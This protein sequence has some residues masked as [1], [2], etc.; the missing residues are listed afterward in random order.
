MARLGSWEIDLVKETSYWSE[1]TQNI[2]E[3]DASYSAD[4]ETGISF[5]PEGKHRDLIT[6]KV[7]ECILYGTPWDVELLM[8]TA[9]GNLKWVRAIGE[10]E[11]VNGT[12]RRLYGSIQDINDRKV[13]ELTLLK[14]L[15][16][17]NTILESIDDAFFAVDRQ[18]IV[19]YWN[20]QVEKQ[21]GPHK[22][23]ML[24]QNLWEVFAD[25]VNSYS[26]HKYAE[27]IE[28][29][30]VVRFEDYYEPMVRWYEISAF[31]SDSGLS[32]YFKDIT[33]RKLTE[34]R[35]N[36]LNANLQK[37][38]KELAMS[39]AELEQFA[40][41]ASHDL[42]EPLRMITGFLTQLER[43]YKDV[44]DEKGK[45]YIDFA[46]DG[47]KRMRHIILDLLEF[48]RVGRTDDKLEK[49][50]LSELV[51]EI[52]ILLMNQIEE[53]SAVI[54]KTNLPVIGSYKTQLR[55]VLLNLIGNA[56]K[57]IKAGI[58]PV[59]EITAKEFPDHWKMAVA[60]NGIGIDAEYF[61]K[62]FIIFQ[63]LHHKDEFP[64]TGMGLAI[65]KKIVESLGGK[66]WVESVEGKGS[67]FYFTVEKTK[68]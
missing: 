25:S 61:E 1:I 64:G 50:D 22:D 40:Y 62:I 63:R 45:R 33:H 34:I 6:Q 51:S 57:Y 46:V 29:N 11:F 19:T 43:K 55:Q 26:Y 41:V 42:Q 4:I 65:T 17:K 52:E 60:D 10:G 39:N 48:S 5:Y 67:T 2:H 12:C 68:E 53:K 21:L 32:V 54:H 31:P 49:V 30:Q 36:E 38:T 14:T 28:T 37:Q 18:W 15:E 44:L 23:K 7:D 58:P 35:L 13:A 59:I 16:E 27:A 20:S 56:L 9:K 24:G 8:I 47:A 66:I 3:V